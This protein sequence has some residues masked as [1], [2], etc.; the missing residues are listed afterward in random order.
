MDSWARL[1]ADSLDAAGELYRAGRFRS[2][3]SRSYFAGFSAVT[4]NLV[5]R[6]ANFAPG[7]EAPSHTSLREM[8]EANLG[9]LSRSRR[10]RLRS[11]LNESY[12]WR[13]D[14]D[15]RPAV[16]VDRMLARNAMINASQVL[17]MLG[18]E[19]GH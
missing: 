17:G 11:M 10:H 1:A 3:V 15:Y 19:H 8:V 14:A 12:A 16:T 6:G 4:H 18:I 13:I 2:S 5:M 7:R 9:G